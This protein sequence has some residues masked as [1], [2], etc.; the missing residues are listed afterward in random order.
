MPQVML[1]SLRSDGSE[2][3]PVLHTEALVLVPGIL[4]QFSPSE[5][6]RTISLILPRMSPKIFNMA[7]EE[8]LSFSHPAY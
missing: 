7:K 5:V 6:E 3:A 4:G 8:K 1:Q 2:G